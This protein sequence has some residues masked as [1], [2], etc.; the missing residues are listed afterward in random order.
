MS[1]TAQKKKFTKTEDVI[2][3]MEDEID[4]TE[5]DIYIIKADR[6]KSWRYYRIQWGQT[7]QESQK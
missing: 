4:G 1:S 7:R 6:H 3:E 5:D 2:Q